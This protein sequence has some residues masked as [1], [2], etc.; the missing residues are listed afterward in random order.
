MLPGI[1]D[2]IVHIRFDVGQ[3]PVH[4]RNCVAPPLRSHSITPFCAKVIIGI[5]RCSAHVLAFKIAA[6]NEN[7]ALREFR[8]LIGGK[9]F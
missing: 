2:E 4:R 3:T 9:S 1:F 6:E 5:A 8:D 7:L